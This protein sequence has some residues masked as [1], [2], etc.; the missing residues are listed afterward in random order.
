M[1]LS[2][3]ECP[4]LATGVFILFLMFRSV[5]N[6]VDITYLFFLELYRSLIENKINK[7]VLVYEQEK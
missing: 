3:T 2:G 7:H 6:F 5:Y 1:I 4:V